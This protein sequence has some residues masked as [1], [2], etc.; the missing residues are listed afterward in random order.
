MAEDDMYGN[1]AK[2]ERI[3]ANLESFVQKPSGTGKYCCKSPKNLKYFEQLIQHFEM[4][5]L[6][7]IRRL[8]VLQV[9]KLITSVVEKDLVECDRD[10]INKVVAF[11]HTTHLTAESKRDFIK[12][13][14]RIWRVLFPER[15]HQGRV[16]ETLTPYA[17][18][19][20][21]RKVDRSKVKLRNDRLTQ[22]QFMNILN[23]FSQDP[24]IQA[25]LM[26]AL[27]SLGRPQEI[28]YTKVKDYEFYDNWAKVWIR[29]HGK[30]GP[31]FLQCID[32]YPYVVEWYHKHPL[33]DKPEAFFFMKLG[34][35]ERF[36]QL[37]NTNINKRL[38]YACK[39]LGIDKTVTCYSLKRNGVSFR[40]ERGD[41][42]M[43]IQHA[44]RW[45]STKQLQ[46]YDMTNQDDALRLELKK[47]GLGDSRAIPQ[48][49]TKVCLFCS[50]ANGFTSDFCVNCKRPLD[51]KKVEEMAK[52]QEKMQHNEVLQRFERIERL[53]ETLLP[54]VAAQ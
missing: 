5:D 17:V 9:L 13:L 10:D 26:L 49:H 15:D 3:I 54:T 4:Q 7:F 44:A 42:D 43:Q 8:R 34:K 41:T 6:S 29:E 19:H 12:D 45:T 52:M 38:K 40:R 22:E 51:R 33:K 14:K 35:R 16:D 46:V 53:F 1:K 48:Q 21:S 36:E 31:G 27:E 37:K 18:R 39:E 50:H 24:Q 2:Y 20:L 30:E 47:R 23:F 32:A 11:S 25:Y 28:L